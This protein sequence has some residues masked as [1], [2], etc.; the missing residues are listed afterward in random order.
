VLLIPHYG[1][2]GAAIGWAISIAVINAM[3]C[4]E[5]GRLMRLRIAD[6]STAETALGAAI[7]FGVPGVVLRLVAGHSVWGLAVWV[8]VGVTAY[9]A[10]GWRRRDTLQLTQL[11]P[12]LGLRRDSGLNP[13]Q[14]AT[15]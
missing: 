7:C 15:P 1:A 2:T 8:A 10:W 3:A 11:A 14:G 9:A 6:A 13:A 4:V 5:V 12:A